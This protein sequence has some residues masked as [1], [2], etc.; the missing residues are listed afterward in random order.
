[1]LTIFY[2]YVFSKYIRKLR[3]ML[4]YHIILFSYLIITFSTL[5][6]YN[7]IFARYSYYYYNRRTFLLELSTH[8]FFFFNLKYLIR[9]SNSV[10]FNLFVI[11]GHSAFHTI[12]SAHVSHEWSFLHAFFIIWWNI[13]YYIFLSANTQKVKMY[14]YNLYDSY[15]YCFYKSINILLLGDI[16]KK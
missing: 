12:F 5:F 10:V 3:I 9:W 16:E 15:L 11:T 8:F 7:S 1:M 4:S 14:T 6:Q 2:F 13:L